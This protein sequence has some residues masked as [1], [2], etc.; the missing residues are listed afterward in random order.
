[1]TLFSFPLRHAGMLRESR[2]TRPQAAQDKRCL[3]FSVGKPACRGCR[4][5]AHRLASPENLAQRSAF[6]TLQQRLE[7]AAH[8]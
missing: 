4:L 5:P 6:V 1:M 8:L 7:L 3:D 2:L